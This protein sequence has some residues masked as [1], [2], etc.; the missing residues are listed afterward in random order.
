MMVMTTTT[1]KSRLSKRKAS[2]LAWKLWSVLEH[3]YRQRILFAIVVNVV[4]IY[5]LCVLCFM[6]CMMAYP[7]PRIAPMNVNH[8]IYLWCR[9]FA[10]H[11]FREFYPS[12]FGWVYTIWMSPPPPS[13]CLIAGAFYLRV[14]A[15]ATG[16]GLVRMEMDR[17]WCA[18]CSLCRKGLMNVGAL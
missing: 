18:V 2:V 5:F 6:C 15:I 1:T 13:E 8:D 16:K 17:W 11:P 14:Q 3:S 12:N 10:S 4:F 9:K 7:S